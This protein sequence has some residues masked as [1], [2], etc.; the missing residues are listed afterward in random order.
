[1][2]G[3]AIQHNTRE[4]TDR[5]REG[6]KA[7]R[8]RIARRIA[9]ALGIGAVTGIVGSSLYRLWANRQVLRALGDTGD[10]RTSGELRRKGHIPKSS[11]ILKPGRPNSTLVAIRDR[12]RRLLGVTKPTYDNEY[13][14]Y[15][16]TESGRPIFYLGN[17][18]NKIS[19]RIARHEAGH[20]KAQQ[21]RKGGPLQYAREINYAQRSAGG[22]LD[23]FNPGRLRDRQGR[24]TLVGLEQEAWDLSGIPASD[25]VRQA[26]LHTYKTH[27]ATRSLNR[28]MRLA[29][30]TA[31]P[32]GIYG[33]Y[34]GDEEDDVEKPSKPT[35][36]G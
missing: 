27:A 26:A 28:Y 33:Y 14:A 21:S 35:V 11:L 10:W 19:E 18:E 7:R 1:M 32:V 23:I 36:K 9:L 25:K 34:G 29:A 31:V 4:S 15:F 13:S 16:V 6:E 24:H 30:V 8:R 20:H 5:K 2:S 17:N 12:V 3:E 22:W